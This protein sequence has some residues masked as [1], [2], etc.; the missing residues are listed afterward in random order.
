[1]FRFKFTV[2]KKLL[3]LSIAVLCIPFAGFSYLRELEQYLRDSLETS[4]IDAAEAVAGP[5]HNQELL[6]P[7]TGE[8]ADKT[9]FVHKLDHPVQLDGYTDD[10][11]SYI[12]W[13]DTYTSASATPE[14][15]LS[16]RFIISR[17]QQYYY[18]L[19][20][21][22]DDDIVYRHA[23]M[24]RAIDNDHV[25][26]IFTGPEGILRDYYFSPADA[27][28]SSPFEMVVR[29]DEFG[30]ESREI[31]YITN[32][33][34]V[35]RTREDGYQMELVVP[36]SA[37][38]DRLGIIVNDVDDAEVREVVA[39]AGTAGSD[40]ATAPGRILQSSPAIEGMIESYV[41]FDGRRIW[42]L[43]EYAQVLASAGKLQKELPTTSM[44]LLYNLILPPVH[45]RFSDDLS[46]A[47]RLQGAEINDAL[48][49]IPTSRWRTSPDGK[50]TIV[51]A[52][53]PVRVD[54]KVKGLVVVEETT[55]NIQMQQRQA[56]AAL[57][58]NT[59][60]V[61]LSVTLLLLIFATRLSI[62]IRRLEQDAH[63]AI[64]SHGRVRGTFQISNA[65]DE[66]GDLSRNYASMLDRLKQYNDYLEKMAGR[67]TH[68]LRTPIAVVQSSLEQLTDIDSADERQHYL[69]R[70]RTGIARLN[71]LVVRLGEATRLELAL[72][73]SAKEETG[74]TLLLENCLEGYRSAYPDVEFLLRLP[75]RNLTALLAPDLFVQMLDK[76]IKNAVDFRT[77]PGPV[78]LIL[79][80]HQTGWAL[81]VINYGPAL[82]EKME[83]QLFD[84]M[85]SVR[86]ERHRQEP[87]LGLGLYIVRLIAEYHHGKVSAANLPGGDGVMFTVTF[88]LV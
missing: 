48:S 42:V 19:L 59:L 82:P 44:N 74:V 81:Q 11:L 67:L 22:Y 7:T 65:T 79:E 53:V 57:F 84:S 5:L 85:V 64:D 17:H 62:R 18:A 61:F 60:F 52:A 29:Y 78:E 71:A 35:W 24:P 77:G 26:L 12:S 15:G 36:V 20:Q 28:E 43:D 38:G 8:P 13:S 34:G 63:A 80:I 47:S 25:R 70:A 54:G 56:M 68:E 73:S 86:T 72:Q 37:V 9:L 33:R 51:S 30:F 87:H 50:A 55:T 16:F 27:G 69:D 39:A 46:G 4:L 40:T 10:W 14:Q 45:Q 83:Q 49:G 6:F 41:R 32:I 75:S 66:I 23:D 31:Q 58:N 76:L 88:P 2:R 3:L 1:M 21:V